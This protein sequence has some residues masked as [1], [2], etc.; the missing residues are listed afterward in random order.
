MGGTKDVA[1]SSDIAKSVAEEL[2]IPVR[3]VEVHIDFLVHWI[4]VLVDTPKVLNIYIPHIGRLY[5]S[6]SNLKNKRDNFSKLPEDN[7]TKLQERTKKIDIA[8]LKEFEKR[9]PEDK[10]TF[11]DYNRH[12]KKSK[13]LSRYFTTGKGFEELEN[14]QNK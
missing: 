1:Y 8:R 3:K 4:K 13:F 6:W 2:G 11:T 12:K 5:A 9:F 14:W 10:S 7:L